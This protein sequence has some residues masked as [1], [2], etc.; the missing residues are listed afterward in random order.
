[1]RGKTA[2]VLGVEKKASAKLQDMRTVRK[3]VKLDDHICVAFA[4]LRADARVLIDKARVE[5]Q[6]YQLNMEVP[7]TVPYIARYVAGVQQRYTQRGGMRPFGI[8]TLIVGFDLVTNEPHL[9]KTDPS[10]AFS[11]WKAAATGRSSK[12]VRE[13]LEKNYDADAADEDVIKLAVKA[14]LEI[15]DSGKNIDICVMRPGGA[16]EFLEADAI[17]ALVDVIEAEAEAE[18]ED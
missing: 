17:S 8:S 1:M 14:L 16:I 5:C 12:S 11:A 13:Y 9:Y 3:I 6:S 7:A 2:V 15:V 18:A 10:G 4:G